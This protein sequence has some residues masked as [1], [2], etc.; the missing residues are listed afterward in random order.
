MEDQPCICDKV[1]ITVW[2]SQ[3]LKIYSQ[4]INSFWDW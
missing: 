2:K 4:F 1:K 3:T